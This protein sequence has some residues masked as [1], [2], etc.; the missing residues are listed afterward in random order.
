MDKIFE[1]TKQNKK[2]LSRF[3]IGIKLLFLILVMK[4]GFNYYTLFILITVFSMTF[5]SLKWLNSPKP[6][7]SLKLLLPIILIFLIVNVSALGMTPGRTNLNYEPGKKVD[8]QFTIVN[9]EGKDLD[10]VIYPQGEFNQ[11]IFLP[12]VSI[13]MAAAEQ[14]KTISYSLSIPELKPGE[15]IGEVVVLQLPGKS[16]GN[17]FVGA[18]VGVAT[19][20][21]IFVPYPGKYAE[22]EM[23][24]VGPDENGK[25]NFVIPVTS[26][27]ELDL[28]RVR[29]T[30]DIY[31]SLNEK[32]E[33]VTADEIII[34]S[35]ERKEIVAV[36]DSTKSAPGPYRAIATILYDESSLKL[37][38][39]FVIGTQRLSL[40]GIE[41]NDFSLGEIAKFEILVEN[42]WSQ[43]LEGVFAEMVVYN[44]NG[45]AMAQFKSPEYNIESLTKS[46]I[47]AFWDTGGVKEGTYDS[48]LFLKYGSNS[49]QKDLKLEVKE[50]EINVVGV[51]YVISKGK[52][53]SGS[54][55]GSG[56][57]TTLIIGIVV[58]ILINLSWFLFLRKKL[59]RK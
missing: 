43:R 56:L 25:V 32:I 27:G 7:L 40:E 10:L 22:A 13:H 24:V 33:T 2:T 48:S 34:P 23:H 58:L 30:V 52:G 44:S 8:L 36:W 17:T 9:S 45:E 4:I 35:K 19:Q 11:S 3:L 41:V 21:A 59:K 54:I 15:H 28:T 31:T 29:A 12:E 57:T 37:E 20:I 6:N 46:L 53:K 38:K 14:S 16:G 18:A 51:G 26:R 47:V 50:N 1:V 42:K 49:E 39:E 55:F 5:L